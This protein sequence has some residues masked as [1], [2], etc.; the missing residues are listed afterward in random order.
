MI[1]FLMKK[2][3]MI[4]LSVA[5]LGSL[6]L[7]LRTGRDFNGDVRIKGGS[8]IEDIRIQQKKKGATLWTLT[9]SK[10]NFTEGEDKAELSDISINLVK[11]DV[12]LHADK[13]VY[14]LSDKSF[15]TD[16]VVKAAS[17]DY[18]ITADSI[19]YEAASG[20]IETGGK[21]TVQGKGFKVE[22]KG[23]KAEAGQKVRILNDV[24]ATF[25]K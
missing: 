10:A 2:I 1:E 12:T 17:K 20:N 3:F 8:F 25:H 6:F 13:G 21:I 11:N 22:G 5:L 9:A 15:T 4:V 16:S 19:D 18:S 24:K 23:L 7:M 14:N